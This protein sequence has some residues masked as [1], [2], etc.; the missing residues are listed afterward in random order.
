LGK[1][2]HWVREATYLPVIVKLTPNVTD[3][4]QLAEVAKESG[5]DAVTAINTLSGLGGIDLQTLHPQ[6]SAGSLGT[7]GGYSGP[8]LKPVALRCAASIA[9]KVSIPLLGSGG[10]SA[11]QDAAEFMA[12]GC[13]LVEIC[14]AVMW[15]GYAIIHQFLHGLSNYL[16]QHQFASS[17]ELVGKALPFLVQHPDL[18]LDARLLAQVNLKEC[19][20]CSLCIQACASGASRAIYRKNKKIAIDPSRCDG[21]GLCLE[22]CPTNAIRMIPCNN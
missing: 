17:A 6:P 14:T 4:I 20:G 12:A 21:C 2:S 8:G 15:N 3:I 11:W 7:F 13:S 22:I 9:Q 16:E 19:T 18:N 10:I 5:A 1:A